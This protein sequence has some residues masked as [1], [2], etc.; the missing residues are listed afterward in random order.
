MKIYIL[1]VN[2][3]HEEDFGGYQYHCELHKVF[4]SRSKAEEYI[5]DNPLNGDD[6]SFQEPEYTIQ[7]LEVNE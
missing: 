6:Y 7:E 1:Y 4:L 3:H 2:Y 5:K